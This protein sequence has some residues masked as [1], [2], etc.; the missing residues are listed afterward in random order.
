[1]ASVASVPAAAEIIGGGG[2]GGPLLPDSPCSPPPWPLGKLRARL[3]KYVGAGGSRPVPRLGFAVLLASGELNPPHLGHVRLLRQAADRLEDAEYA[4]VGAWLSP[5][6]DRYVQEKMR[7][8]GEPAFSARF[9]IELA[10]RSAAGD[11]LVEIGAWEALQPLE[12]RPLVGPEVAEQLLLALFDAERIEPLR[13]AKGRV[14][15]RVFYVAGAEHFRNVLSNVGRVRRQKPSLLGGWWSRVYDNNKSLGVVV[16][17][18][19]GVDV[20]HDEIPQVKLDGDI[21]YVAVPRGLIGSRCVQLEHGLDDAAGHSSTWLRQVV[22]RG[23]LTIARHAMASQE[24]A[25]LLLEPSD[26]ERHSFAVDFAKYACP[27]MASVASAPAAAEIIGGGGGGGPLPPDSPCSPP[28]WPLRKLRTKLSKYV[29][30]G[31]SRPVPRL[32]F[33]VL[34]ASGELNP[35]HLGH[36][37]LLRQAADRLE[38]AEYAVVGA[39][40]SPL[41]D[42]YVQE[43]MRRRGEPAFSARFRIELARRSVAGD[44]LVEI[45]DWEALRQPPEARSLVC[46]EVAEQLLHALFDAEDIPPLKNAKGRVHVKVFYV[47]GAEHFKNFLSNVG[48]VRRQN[49]T[50]LGGWWSRVYD[51]NK[52]LGVV[53]VARA[54]VDVPHDEIPQVKLDGDI[55]YVAVP[56]GLI[57]ARCGWMFAGHTSTWLRQVL[58]HGDLAIAR[59]AMASQE[60]AQLLLE[61]FIL[62][63]VVL[64]FLL[65]FLLLLFLLSFSFF[66]FCFFFFLFFF[67]FFFF[68]SLASLFLCILLCLSRLLHNNYNRVL[69]SSLKL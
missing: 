33:T 3:S 6:S 41:S 61:L 66:L 43:K 17:A 62:V 59:H 47:A 44:D 60:A 42:R 27:P 14:H 69:P 53:V 38:D 36:V 18:R 25:Q 19:A 37:R 51:Y 7:R 34:L 10:R 48:R 28:L 21:M 52:S 58:E 16:V 5:L 35:P 39:W 64:V 8:T 68:L 32:G 13:N 56:P 54:G 65:F 67:F 24:A 2:G 40:L 20:P 26:E 9:R 30:A 31:G 63:L 50:L 55:M 23:D 57:G 1:M 45:S 15:V 49:P 46:P 22:E 29:G 4:V 11:D 12:P